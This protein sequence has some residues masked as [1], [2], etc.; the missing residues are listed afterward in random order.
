MA[1]IKQFF[2]KYWRKILACI[3]V[4]AAFIFLNISSFV[5]YDT[6]ATTV[7][8]DS[9][10]S[11][12]PLDSCNVL[13]INLHGTLYTYLPKGYMDSPDSNKD[14]ASSEEIIS[15]INSAKDDDEIKAII[16]EVD[17]SGGYP[18]AGEEIAKALKNAGKPSVAVIRQSGLSAAYWAASGAD[19]IFASRNSDVGSIGVTT[20]Y[21]DNVA[22]NKK[23]GLEYVQL[24]SGK[25]KDAGS[26]DKV[27]T[28]EE[29]ALIVRDLKIT[30]ENFIKDI[31]ANRK[32][33]VQKISEIADGSSVLGERAKVL[34][35]IDEIGNW[36]E[37]RTYIEKEISEKPEVCW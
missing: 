21:L 20:S 23:D 15:L 14:V 9:M 7:A 26:P 12:T 16:L 22:K 31:A 19:H 35:L 11:S 4:A 27:L 36:T 1:K 18:V 34:G 25:F 2:K 29:K 10:D 8:T 24:S 33:S 37:A 30:H 13:G 3:G 32:V 6:A 28:E 17:S 5:I